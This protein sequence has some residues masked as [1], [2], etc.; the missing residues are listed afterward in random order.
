MWI[1]LLSKQA[2]KEFDRSPKEIREA[3]LAWQNLVISSG[4]QA[5]TLINGYWD[6]PLKGNWAGARASSLNK[7]WRVIYRIEE[8]QVQVLVLRVSSHDYRR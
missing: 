5:L 6:H 2:Q 7:E 3:F 1:V 4:P 8:R